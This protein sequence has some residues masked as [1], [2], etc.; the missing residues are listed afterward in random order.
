MNGHFSWIQVLLLYFN[1][2]RLNFQATLRKTFI[3][4]KNVVLHTF[5]FRFFC[6]QTRLVPVR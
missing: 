2:H 4:S 6:V 3:S 5:L 1:R